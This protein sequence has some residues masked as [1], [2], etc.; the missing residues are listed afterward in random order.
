MC[1]Q[2]TADSFASQGSFL[3]RRKRVGRNGRGDERSKEKRL[4]RKPAA[5]TRGNLLVP[6]ERV[7]MH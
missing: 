3:N 6:R 2:E 4:M 5:H 1:G 7:S